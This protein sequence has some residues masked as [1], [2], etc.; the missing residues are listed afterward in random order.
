MESEPDR[1]KR[2]AEQMVLR[3][4]LGELWKKFLLAQ[5][6]PIHELNEV[7]QIMLNGL[8]EMAEKHGGGDVFNATALDDMEDFWKGVRRSVLNRLAKS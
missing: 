1:Q 7:S 4:L 6:E 3:M 2:A 8:D 5:E